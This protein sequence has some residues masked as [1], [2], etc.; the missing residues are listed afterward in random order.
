METVNQIRRLAL[1]VL[2]KERE[3]ELIA[4]HQKGDKKATELLIRHN[5]GLALKMYKYYIGRGLDEDE[6][7][8]YAL[9]GIVTAA[10]KFEPKRNNKFSTL[11]S[12]W[13][14]QAIVR[15][16]EISGDCIRKPNNVIMEMTRLKR[17]TRVHIEKF[18]EKPTSQQL[19][20]AYN[21]EFKDSKNF[22]PM[23]AEKA[24]KLGSYSQG[25]K[26]LD[27]KTGSEE[28]GFT[29]L[30]FMADEDDLTEENA[31]ENV[32]KAILLKTLKELP[33][34]AA[35]FITYRYGLNDGHP[36]T[37]AETGR[38]FDMDEKTVIRTEQRILRRLRTI[39][40]KSEVNLFEGKQPI[41]DVLIYNYPPEDKLYLMEL[42]RQLN[43]SLTLKKVANR[44]NKVPIIIKD[45]EYKT[46]I[47]LRGNL[48]SR[49]YVIKVRTRCSK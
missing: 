25:V 9:M 37:R 21:I 5:S 47:E 42:V 26:S 35:N 14:R 49:N 6:L 33:Q 16:I 18:Q 1:P 22:K 20:D 39:I 17:L 43:P 13:V 38:A 28:D 46:Q 2:T 19:A 11:A 12:W 29:Q 30:D 27:E 4:A 3:Y 8:Q 31:E 32:D 24:Y 48:D 44:V 15:A 23:T 34:F 45:L 40:N 10:N 36:K 41:Y 7:V